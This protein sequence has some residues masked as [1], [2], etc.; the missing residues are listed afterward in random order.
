VPHSA[1]KEYLLTGDTS[2]LCKQCHDTG[3]PSFAEAHNRIPVA[4]A[5]C[6]RC[7]EPHAAAN[8]SLLHK[9]MH[10]PFKNKKCGECHE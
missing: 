9:G 10:A 2:A 1:G 8:E 4:G 5:D 3:L 6:S 7:H